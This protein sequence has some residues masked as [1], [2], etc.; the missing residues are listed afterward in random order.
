MTSGKIATDQPGELY[1]GV[2]PDEEVRLVV[3]LI[4]K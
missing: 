3:K 1:Q 2:C 4:K